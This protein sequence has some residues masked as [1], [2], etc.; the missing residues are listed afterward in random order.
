MSN[1]DYVDTYLRKRRRQY[2]ALNNETYA[3][4]ALGLATVIA[5]VW[6]NI[7][8]SYHDFWHTP[9]VLRIGSWSL[10]LTLHGWVDE[11]LMAAFFFLVGLDVRRELTLGELRIPGR[12]LLPAAAAV[13]ALI[14]PTVI[15]LLIAGNSDGAAAWGTVISTDTAFALGMLALI[16]PRNAPRLKLFL[17]AFAVIDDIG[18][19]LVIAVF[20]TDHLNLVALAVA[21]LGLLGVW[22]LAR[23]GVWRS[24]PYLILAIGIWY[25]VY[26]SGVHATIAGVLIALI[27]PVYNLRSGDLEAS[28]ALYRLFRQAPTPATARLV[29]DAMAYS[30][31]LNQRLA[32]VLPPYVNFIVVPLFALANAGVALSG[33]SLGLAA[34]SPIT[35]GIIAGLVLGKMLGVTLGAGLVL[36]FVPSARLPGL[37]LPR[38]AGVGALAGMGFTIS[39]LVAN[40]A[41]DDEVLCDQARVGV[42]AASLLA[43]V[44]ATVLFRLGD[45]LAPLPPPAG[46]TLPIPVDDQRD[47]FW[48]SPDAP[49][50]LVNYADVSDEGRWRLTEAFWDVREQVEEGKLRLVFR[51]RAF[52]PE[53]M[54]A[55]LALE[56]A[57]QQG[58]MLEM[59]TALVEYQGEIDEASVREVAR[60]IGLDVDALSRRMASGVDTARIEDDSLDVAELETRDGVVVYINGQRLH[61][62]VN[63]WRIVESIREA[64]EQD[65]SGA[66]RR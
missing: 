47:H 7:G 12:A 62:F 3:A 54:T 46:E 60:G 51:H 33:E 23:R 50:T 35:W 2:R 43:L 16:G 15:Y 66:S 30:M 32:F 14:I 44:L 65:E 58:R 56:A 20:Y 52:T 38:I 9:A 49:V 64:T 27:M 48:G 1:L 57:D 59:H 37:D 13:T 19:L 63:R 36:R 11:G 61:G 29:R 55:A 22:L 18:A 5:L 17:L 6:A 53:A 45:R 24:V 21:G 10:E 41:L 40:L 42:L 4:L 34:L 26:L 39:L 25:A 8:H 28:N 31:P